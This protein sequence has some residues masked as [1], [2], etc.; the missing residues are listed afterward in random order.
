MKK[1]T[2]SK[3]KRVIWFT[4]LIGLAAVI[5]GI[6]TI[7]NYFTKTLFDLISNGDLEL[8]DEE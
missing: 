6:V 3:K 1:P 2:K 7:V 5:C 4:A 8:D